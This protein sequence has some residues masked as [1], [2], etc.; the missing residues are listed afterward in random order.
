MLMY[1]DTTDEA[2]Y[3]LALRREREAFA[4]LI[5]SKPVHFVITITFLNHRTF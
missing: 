5:T 1:Q 4:T 2:L 3:L